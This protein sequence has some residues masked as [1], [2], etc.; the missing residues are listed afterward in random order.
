[1]DGFDFVNKNEVECAV[2]DY[3]EHVNQRPLCM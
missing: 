1:M 2:G 3:V